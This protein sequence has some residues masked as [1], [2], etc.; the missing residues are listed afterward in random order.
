MWI[1]L[2]FHNAKSANSQVGIGPCYALDETALYQRVNFVISY[3]H[4]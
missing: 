1:K 3:S 4:M 2:L